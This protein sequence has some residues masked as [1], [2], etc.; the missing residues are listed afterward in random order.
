MSTATLSIAAPKVGDAAPDFSLPYATKDTIVWEGESLLATTK[1]S[2]V[3]LA[4]YPADWSGGCTKEV[5]TFRDTWNEFA[6]LG[7]TVWAISGDYAYSH[8]AWAEHHSLPFRLLSDHDHAVAK[9]YGSYND[10]S[11]MNA[12]TV[13]LVG[14]DGKIKYANLKYSVKDDSDF[15]ALKK[16]LAGLK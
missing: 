4:F 15:T 5:C 6:S 11:G 12:R 16:A 1:N 10:E 13:F 14:K 9:A 8:K 7:V 2:P 3:L